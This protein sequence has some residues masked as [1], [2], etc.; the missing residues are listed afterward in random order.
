MT[1]RFG[2]SVTTRK[3][4]I[5]VYEPITI[6]NQPSNFTGAVGQKA[7]FTVK[8]KEEGVTYQWQYKNSDGVWRNST[9]T[10]ANTSKLSIK[11]TEARNGQQYR[12]II[13]NA[14]TYTTCTKAVKIIV[15]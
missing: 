14:T 2:I 5:Y 6:H 12:C 3:V 1:D 11:I 15:G 7:T 13:S 8:V 10:G 9:A 4:N